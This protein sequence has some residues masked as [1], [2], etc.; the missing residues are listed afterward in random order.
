MESKTLRPETIPELVEEIRD[1][2][3]EQVQKMTSYLNGVMV[4]LDRNWEE[5]K[6]LNRNKEA[7]IRERA[8]TLAIQAGY[9][10]GDLTKKAQEILDFCLLNQNHDPEQ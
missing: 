5:I 6:L 8:M 10:Q 4:S 1:A 7:T 3:E 9:S 2:Q